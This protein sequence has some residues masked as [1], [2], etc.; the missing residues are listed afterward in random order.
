M[1][2]SSAAED[3]PELTFE[4]ARNQLVAIVTQLEAGSA[5]LS[6]SMAL[7]ERGEELAKV[8]QNWLDAARA[9]ISATSEKE[10]DR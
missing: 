6:E 10:S 5:P 8:C 9:K 2:N 3:T 7:W 4:E 1:A